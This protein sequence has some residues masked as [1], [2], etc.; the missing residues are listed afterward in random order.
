MKKLTIIN[1]NGA[2][3][4]D[5]REV[6]QMIGKR[7]ANLLRDIENYV[8]ILENS[9]L[10]S[11]DFFIKDNYK[12]EGNNK[13]YDC[14]LLTKQGCEMV[15]NKMTGQKGV[16]FTAQ[17]VQAFN[18]MDRFIQG[19]LSINEFKA[20]LENQVNELVQNK[21]NE[22]EDKCSSYYRPSSLEKTNI[23]K[24]IKQRLGILRANEEYESVKQ[25]I[26]IKLGATK[27]EDIDIETLKNSLN[28][29]DE[30]IRVI[31][32][33]RPQQITLWD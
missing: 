22:I 7:H 18:K 27:W 31:K 16:L 20:Q 14:Y 28:I 19:N 30:S 29:I 2:N 24:Y 32:L 23:S 8:S 25:R 3:V 6:A 13:T 11:Q 5:S 9:K 15:A 26:L 21:I 33:D 17:Y 1:Y 10:S 12:V 4:T